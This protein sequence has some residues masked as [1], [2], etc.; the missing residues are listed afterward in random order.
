M[1]GWFYGS[2][3]NPIQLMNIALASLDELLL[4]FSKA[5]ASEYNWS[6]NSMIYALV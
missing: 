1:N 2:N 6:S 4:L 5:S 3:M